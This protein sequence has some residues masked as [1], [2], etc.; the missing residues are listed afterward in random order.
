MKI[1]KLWLFDGIEIVCYKFRTMDYLRDNIIAVYAAVVATLVLFWDIFKWKR[2]GPRILLEVSP[3]MNIHGDHRIPED[4]QHIS[5][6]AIN[7]GDGPT[8][9]THLG[10]YRYKNW[11]QRLFGKPDAQYT[12]AD[13]GFSSLPYRLDPGT[14]WDGIA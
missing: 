11:I 14:T 13:T 5:I 3:N 2:S 7:K 12:V 6:R 10:F 1:S 9:I 4:V 8:S